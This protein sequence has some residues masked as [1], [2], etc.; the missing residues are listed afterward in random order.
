[1][2]TANQATLN[3]R[4]RRL[5]DQPGDRKGDQLDALQRVGRDHPQRG[6]E[7]RPAGAGPS[8]A[9]R[10]PRLRRRAGYVLR[11]SADVRRGEPQVRK[12]GPR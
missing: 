11:Q 3:S 7:N 6:A 12:C 10:H 4:H 9:V 5:P 8:E 1:M 2:G